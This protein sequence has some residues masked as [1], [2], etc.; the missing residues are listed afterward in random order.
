M[1]SLHFTQGS[2]AQPVNLVNK[3]SGAGTDDVPLV[4]SDL[5]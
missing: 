5:S 1:Q 2:W 4:K 3:D